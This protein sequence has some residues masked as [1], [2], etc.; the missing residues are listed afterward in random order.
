MAKSLTPCMCQNFS[1]VVDGETVTTGC[2]IET[3]SR[4]APGHDAKLKSLFIR[5]G[6]VGAEVAAKAEDGSVSNMSAIEAAAE[7]GFGETVEKGI[8]N[9]KAREQLRKQREQVKA[10][11]KIAAD[12]KKAIAAQKKADAAAAKAALEAAEAAET[13][14][15]DEDSDVL[16]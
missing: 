10:D 8:E 3:L 2:D 14:E 16:V 6:T 1:A 11:N 4:F 12:A 15:A 13:A 9:A 5:V 7:F